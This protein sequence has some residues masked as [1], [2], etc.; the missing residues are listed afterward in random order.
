[1][2]IDLALETCQGSEVVNVLRSITVSTKPRVYRFP[3]SDLESEQPGAITGVPGARLQN[4]S[5]LRF[6]PNSVGKANTL[7]IDDLGL[8]ADEGESGAQSEVEAG[9]T[10]SPEEPAQ[11]V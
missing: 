4:V 3:F 10:S 5:P 9:D 11:T 6:I 8:Y 7:H 2:T 1:M